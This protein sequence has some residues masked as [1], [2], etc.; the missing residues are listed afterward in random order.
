LFS[1][2]FSSSPLSAFWKEENNS[3]NGRLFY[4]SVYIETYSIWVEK[5]GPQF[6]LKLS[7]REGISKVREGLGLGTLLRFLTLKSRLKEGVAKQLEISNVS[8]KP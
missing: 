6:K 8:H 7:G 4:G 1:F 2:F 5:L 3:Q